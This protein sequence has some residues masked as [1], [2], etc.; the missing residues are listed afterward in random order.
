MTSKTSTLDYLLILIKWRNFILTN[1]FVV[2]ILAAIISL[3]LPKWYRASATIMPPEI[4]VEG[5]GLSSIVEKFNMGGLGLEASDK[6]LSYM[7]ILESRT[8]IE[9]VAKKFDLISVYN[10][11]NMEATI[12]TLRSKVSAE[13]KREGTI[14]VS[15]M[16]KVSQRAAD[17][18]NAFIFYLDSLNTVFNIE[19][20]Q[21]DR[22]FIGRRFEQN[23][24]DISRAEEALTAFQKENNAVSLPEQTEA[25]IM[26]AA[27]IQAQIIA[28]EVE[29][30]VKEK[31]LSP[32]HLEISSIKNR[33]IE[34]RKK[35]D[36]LTFGSETENGNPSKGNTSKEILISFSELPELGLQYARLLREVKVQNKLYELLFQQYEEA[37]IQ[38]AKD[39]PTIQVLDVAVPAIKKAKPRRVAIVLISGLS[40]SLLL[41]IMILLYARIEF[42]EE[43]DNER[44]SKIINIFS[45]FKRDINI[46]KKHK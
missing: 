24:S 40:T 46:F 38:E 44:Y 17:M 18:A 21:N 23:K 43:E 29:L 20:A 11:P 33:I 30:G 39:T 10:T 41:I 45:I 2:C 28:S 1:F 4:E 12:K 25:T 5:L 19:K 31:S 13:I 42:L 36:K 27:E 15:V 22:I 14:S 32:S 26:A 6:A 9:S 3:L 8:L 34:L 16:D 7:A 37:K 35:L